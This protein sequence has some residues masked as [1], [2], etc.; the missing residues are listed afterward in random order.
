MREFRMPEGP[1]CAAALALLR[2]LT[3]SWVVTLG[4]VLHCCGCALPSSGTPGRGAVA[5]RSLSTRK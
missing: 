4:G 1:G 5:K 3:A 2:P